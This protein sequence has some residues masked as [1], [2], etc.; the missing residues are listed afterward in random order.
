[1]ATEKLHIGD[2]DIVIPGDLLAEGMSYLP[3]GRAYREDQKL[4]A[5]S[6]GLVSIKGKVIKVI[7]LSGAY[8]PKAGD[9]VIGRINEVHNRGWSV[10]IGCPY[11][12]DLNVGDATMRYIDSNRTDLTEIYDIGDYV[13]AGIRNISPSK[14]VRLSTR[15]RQFFKLSDGNIIKV[16]PTKIPRIIGK[17]GSM[18]SMIKNHTG[19]KIFV[20]QN[21]L[22]W[23]E[24]KDENVAAVARIIK[25]IEKES[26][27]SGLTEKVQ[28]ILDKEVKK[29][30]T[31]K[32]KEEEVSQW[33][34]QKADQQN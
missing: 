29:E 15:D 34:D 18:I 13:L 21:G 5:S 17:A 2:K 33:E 10:D 11:G 14:Y 1:M 30:K 19:C 27:I 7:P 9:S 23:I 24:G 31:A 25:M 6:V 28:K 3:S 12:A 22:V 26:H 16:S 8:M 32:K 20:G 4:F